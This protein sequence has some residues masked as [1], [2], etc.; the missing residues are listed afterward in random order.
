[1]KQKRNQINLVLVGVLAFLLVLVFQNCAPKSMAFVKDSALKDSSIAIGDALGVECN[2]DGQVLRDGQSVT[3]YRNST[4]S[5]TQTCQSETRI[6]DNGVLS[7]SNQFATCVAQNLGKQT[8]AVTKGSSYSPFKLLLIID[9]SYTISQSQAKL[10]QNIDSLIQPLAGKD[11]QVKII[12]TS[13]VSSTDESK[14]SLAYFKADGTSKKV[15]Y[16]SPNNPEY[17]DSQYVRSEYI[18]YLVEPTGMTYNLGA[19]ESDISIKNKIDAIKKYI[20]SLGVKGRDNEQVLCPLAMHLFNRTKNSF[21]QQ[22]DTTAVVVVS[23][24][25][26]SSTFDKCYK[27]IGSRY[28]TVLSQVVPSIDRYVLPGQMVTVF[29]D[30]FIA[31]YKDGI[32]SDRGIVKK[33]NGTAALG[34]DIV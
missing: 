34:R 15:S 17:K 25:N 19:Q 27:Q 30:Y 33:Y 24:E 21:F 11:V 13:E 5:I 14:T 12:S 3:A 26:D 31:E 8:I 9:D 28:G 16:F 1:M 29:F 18:N 32:L 23:D 7:G 2:F 20:V 22:G 6:C 4:V 10:A